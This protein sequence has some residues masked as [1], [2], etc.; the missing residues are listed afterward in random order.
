MD[1][2]KYIHFQRFIYLKN[3]RKSSINE[4][5]QTLNQYCNFTNKNPT[6]LIE[7]A[8]LDENQHTV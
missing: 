2:L 3:L 5:T 6:E 7:E 4:Y 1:I 8:E